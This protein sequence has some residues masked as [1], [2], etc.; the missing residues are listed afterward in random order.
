M[1]PGIGV[2]DAVRAVKK[3]RARGGRGTGEGGG[4]EG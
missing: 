3:P 2:V 1:P 4:E